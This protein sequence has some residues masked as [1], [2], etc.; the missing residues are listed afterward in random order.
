[1]TKISYIGDKPWLIPTL[2]TSIHPSA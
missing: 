1:M 2:R